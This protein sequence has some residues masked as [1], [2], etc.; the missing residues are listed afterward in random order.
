MS[1]YWAREA[2]GVRGHGG[3]SKSVRTGSIDPVTQSQHEVYC[4]L[5]IRQHLTGQGR[6]D[7]GPILPRAVED[8]SFLTAPALPMMDML[9]TAR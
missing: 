4:T 1:V 6:V 2:D 5:D 9:A 3:M 8:V 7:G